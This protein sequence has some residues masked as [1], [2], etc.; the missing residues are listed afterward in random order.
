M[1]ICADAPTEQRKIAESWN[2]L[3]ARF[4]IDSLSRM[5][6]QLHQWQTTTN[7]TH[8]QKPV[9]QNSKPIEFEGIKNQHN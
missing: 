7:E 2:I 5:A 8:R 1:P 4:E 3:A 6:I 9:G